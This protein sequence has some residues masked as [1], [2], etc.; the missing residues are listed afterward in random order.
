MSVVPYKELPEAIMW[1]TN[2][3][4]LPVTLL[5]FAEAPAITLSRTATASRSASTASVC[6]L[7]R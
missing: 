3:S 6:F 1:V 5:S 4:H 2:Y 7:F